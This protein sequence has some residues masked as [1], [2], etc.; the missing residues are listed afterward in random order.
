[1]WLIYRRLWAL[2]GRRPRRN[3]P[4]LNSDPLYNSQGWPKHRPH[5]PS[6]DM[7]LSTLAIALLCGPAVAQFPFTGKHKTASCTA[8]N[9]AID[10]A[11]TIEI[12]ELRLQ[13]YLPSALTPLLREI[14]YVD[15]NPKAKETLVL[16]HGW[17]GIW[18][19]WKHQI[20][21]FKVRQ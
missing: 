21:E 19:T 16:V 1:M 5:D 11:T 17:P 7:L 15:V 10:E 9:R 3:W 20:D 4:L 14:D 18:S 2:Q 6:V 13:E 12:R 8:V